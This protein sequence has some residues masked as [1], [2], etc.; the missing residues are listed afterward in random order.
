MKHLIT[1]ILLL[2]FIPLFAPAQTKVST[3][4]PSIDVSVRR[5]MADGND[6]FIDLV[7]TSRGSWRKLIFSTDLFHPSC[8][9]Y[10]DEGNLYQ[11]GDSSRILFEIDGKRSYWYPELVI[12]NGV[13]RKIRIIVKNVDEYAT[14]F[15]KAYFHYYADKADFREN[16][17]VM[18]VTDLPISR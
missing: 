14:Q 4:S 10:D 15:L 1:S 16:E 3:G 5:A 12:E 9:L 7:I 8:R 11:S 17:H 18:S 2:F 6:V 13:P